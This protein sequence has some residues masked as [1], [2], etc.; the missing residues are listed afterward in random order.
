MACLARALWWVHRSLLGTSSQV[1]MGLWLSRPSFV[2]ARQGRRPPS[3]DSPHSPAAQEPGP[4][5]SPKVTQPSAH[6]PCLSTW[7]GTVT[8]AASR[9]GAGHAAKGGEQTRLRAALASFSS[10]SVRAGLGHSRRRRQRRAGG[11]C[12]P[13]S[14]CEPG[15]SGTVSPKPQPWSA[16][17]RLHLLGGQTGV[18]SP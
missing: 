16:C 18:S 7:E 10:V 3:P 12:L 4:V 6:S 11:P 14:P 8:L 2:A 5:R 17:S 9:G 13:P 15:E 1:L